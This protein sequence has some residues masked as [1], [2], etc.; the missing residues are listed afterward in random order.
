MIITDG[1]WV[2]D[3]HFHIF[4][5]LL[6]T[7]MAAA[8]LSLFSPWRPDSIRYRSEI[9][10]ALRLQGELSKCGQNL[11]LRHLHFVPIHF[12]SFSWM[13]LPGCDK[14]G[15]FLPPLVATPLLW[16]LNPLFVAAGRQEKKNHPPNFPPVEIFPRNFVLVDKGGLGAAPSSWM[17][18]GR[19]E[20]D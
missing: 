14:P 3:Q 16:L 10:N 13:F 6:W 18:N 9:G 19:A 8:R 17:L 15:L 2:Q 7:P 11:C 5:V 4:Q 1:F 12:P 20:R